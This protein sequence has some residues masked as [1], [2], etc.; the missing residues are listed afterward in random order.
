MRTF[1]LLLLCSTAYSARVTKK[2]YAITDTSCV[3]T[4]TMQPTFYVTE[5]VDTEVCTNL[6][7]NND[8]MNDASVRNRWCDQSYQRYH[9]ETFSLPGCQCLTSPA[10]CIKEWS[11]GVCTM[12]GQI[13]MIV[14]CDEWDTQLPNS[15]TT[16]INITTTTVVNEGDT[17]VVNNIT[18][19]DNTSHHYN[20]TNVTRNVSVTN[21]VEKAVNTTVTETIW[22][23]SEAAFFWG[24][25]LVFFAVIAV[26]Y[27]VYATIT[28]NK[29]EELKAN[30]M[31][32]RYAKLKESPR[33]N[34]IF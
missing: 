26:A 8:G 20:I 34:R 24:T 21:I 13:P 3:G 22:G 17:H 10:I 12:V 32:T 19:I 31:G 23:V 14:E 30:A 29:K 33:Q 11:L 1:V 2:V 7:T 18:N 27:F 25:A 15:A 9:E 4:P 16:V 5:T 28:T 6:D